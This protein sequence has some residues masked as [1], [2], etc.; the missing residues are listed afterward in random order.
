[1]IVM[2]CAIS[3]LREQYCFTLCKYCTSEIKSFVK[4]CHANALFV[5]EIASWPVVNGFRVAL[6]KT[7]YIIIAKYSALTH[8]Q[9]TEFVV[10]HRDILDAELELLYIFLTQ[11]YPCLV[12]RDTENFIYFS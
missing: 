1:M 9:A 11:K 2:I 4:C 5:T 3:I 10:K 7:Y 6:A 12:H 8:L